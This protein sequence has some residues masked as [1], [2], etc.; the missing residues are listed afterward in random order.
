MRRECL[1]TRAKSLSSPVSEYHWTGT[2]TGTKVGNKIRDCGQAHGAAV[3]CSNSFYAY[4]RKRAYNEMALS[5]GDIASSL[6]E[7]DLSTK[8]FIFQQTM[9]RIKDPKASL[10]FYTRVMGMRFVMPC[11]RLKLLSIYV[12]GGVTGYVPLASQSPYPIIVY[13]VAN[14]RPHL[15]HFWG[16]VNFAI[17]HSHFLFIELCIYLINPFNYVII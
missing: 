9:F 12:P 10:D 15:S 11:D 16:D 17:T 14:Y 1:P 4:V 8:D 2:V 3:F 7:P 6:S 5:D 13:F